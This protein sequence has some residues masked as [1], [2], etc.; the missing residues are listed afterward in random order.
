M[1]GIACPMPGSLEPLVEHA[2]KM[3]IPNPVFETTRV[4]LAY[5]DS[6]SKLGLEPEIPSIDYADEILRTWFKLDTVKEVIKPA[7]TETEQIVQDF[8]SSGVFPEYDI[9]KNPITLS[10][11]SQASLKVSAR[12]ATLLDHLSS[13]IGIPYVFITKET[14]KEI[15]EGLTPWSGEPAFYLGNKIY[16]VS[17]NINEKTAFHEFAH[18]FIRAIKVSNPN[19]YAKLS[20]DLL[21]TV[22][23]RDLLEAAKAKY[24]TSEDDPIL[25]EEAMV[26]ALTESAITRPESAFNTF[27][28]DL[29]YAIKQLLRK[30]FGQ[31]QKVSIEKLSPD[32]TFDQLADMLVLDQFD[33]DLDAINQDD[34]VAYMTDRDAVMQELLSLENTRLQDSTD[35]LFNVISNQLKKIERKK[36]YKTLA[37]ILKDAYNRPDL[38]EIR[39]NLA[40]YQTLSPKFISEFNKIKDDIEYAKKHAHA[41]L[42]SMERLKKMSVK[43][44]E[45][46]TKMVKEK[47]N[48]D[49]VATVFYYNN[50][51]TS[52][53]TFTDQFQSVLKEAEKN[54]ELESDSEIAV[55]TAS[56]SAEITKAKGLTNEIYKEGVSQI[57][58][59]TVAPLKQTIDEKFE[60]IIKD[61]KARELGDKVIQI[62]MAD[63]YGL[64]GEDLNA[65][66]AFK[67]RVDAGEKLRGTE[68]QNYETLKLISYKN[69][70][71]INDEKID[72]LMSGALGD[73]HATNSFLEGYIYNQ[74]LIVSNFSLWV[75]N[76]MTDVLT[77]AQMLGNEFIKDVQP[78]LNRAGYNQANPAQFFR[79]ITF[80]D[81]RGNKE[82]NGVKEYMV[83][84]FINPHKDYRKALMDM[85]NN[86]MLADQKALET[87]DKS[88]A[89]LLRVKRDEFMRNF[90]HTPYTDEYYERYKIFR[91]LGENDE[92]GIAA[93]ALRKEKQDQIRLR[94]TMLD[95]GTESENE[96]TH[97]EIK[98]LV[99]EYRYLFSHYDEAGNLKSDKDIQIADRLRE[100]RDASKDIFREELLPN[101]FE[102]TIKAHEEMLIAKGLPRGSRGFNNMRSNFIRENTRVKINK[103][104]YE[105][106]ESLYKEI[107]QI[108]KKIA[109]KDVDAELNRLQKELNDLMSPYKDDDLQVEGTIINR[110]KVA[111]VKKLQQQIDALRNK[112]STPQGLT[113]EE[114]DQYNLLYYK[115]RNREPLTKEEQTSWNNLVFKKYST[116][117]SKDEIKRLAD[118]YAE[119]N[120]LSETAPTVYYLDMM[121][122]YYSNVSDDIREEFYNTYGSQD[123]SQKLVDIYLTEE[124]YNN[125]VSK[126]PAFKEWYDA[127]HIFTKLSK[128]NGE[129]I[130]K[131]KRV[132]VWDTTVPK[133]IA[134]Y[135]T[136]SFINSEGKKEVMRGIPLDTFYRRV[137]KDEYISKTVTM[138][139]ALEK[140]DPTLATHDNKGNALPKLNA[141][142]NRFINEKFFEIKKDKPK[143]D[144]L[145]ALMKWSLK[146]QDGKE[147]SSKLYLDLPRFGLDRYE[148]MRNPDEN[149]ISRWW[150]NVR[151]MFWTQ[152]DEDSFDRGFNYKE[153]IMLLPGELFD[154][155][156]AGV[157][158]SG[159]SK[160]PDNEVSLDG[161]SS[162][163]RY[164]LSS[165]KQKALIEMLPTARALQAV[166]HDPSNY[167]SIQ[168]KLTQF[169]QKNRSLSKMYDQITKWKQPFR[170]K[171]IRQKAIDNFI[172]REFEGKINKG[173]IGSDSES[174]RLQKIAQTIMS[175]SAF[176][177][178]A[179]DIPSA[180]KNDFSLRIQAAIEAAGG[181]YFDH[182]SL[183]KGTFWANNSTWEISL[184][185][186]S[187]KP[188]THNEQLVMLFDAFQGRF[189]DK[190]DEMMSRSLTKD[191]IGNLKWMT[192]F[193]K[194]TELNSTLSIFGAMM[195]H[196]KNVTRVVDGKETKISYMDAWETVDGQIRLKEGV[197][198]EWGQEGAKFKQFKNKVQGVINNLAGSFAKFD[199]AEADRYFAYRFAIAFKR[200]F[201]RMFLHRFQYRGSIKNIQHRYDNAVG[202][203][204]M[205][206]YIEGLRYLWRSIKAGSDYARGAT[207]SEKVAMFRMLADVAY[208]TLF[209]M[210]ISMLFDFD[211]D[212]ED[213]FKKLRAKSGPLPFLGTGEGEDDFKFKGWLSNHALYMLMQLKQEQTQWLPIPGIGA[214]NYIDMLSLDSVAMHNTW[215]NYK[216][217]GT[218]LVDHA[219]HAIF[220]TDDSKAYFDQRE[221]PY[222]WMQ[223]GGS[224]TMTY[225]A[226]SYGLTG[227]SL[228]PAM[229]VTNF[230]KAQNWR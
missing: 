91:K 72:Y 217:I 140:G 171:S 163:L 219:S 18:P 21:N 181:K 113:K 40:S 149:P 148:I 222:D 167:T 226:R 169:Q 35:E 121:N 51:L 99:R 106:R 108:E 144:A 12:V 19:L 197:D 94:K 49:T 82:G 136:H 223:E 153:Q 147:D 103:A 105:K 199:Y 146:F 133:N 195:Y 182:R 118:L 215:D 4:Y 87:G 132:K 17:E 73:A 57:I 206:Y 67:A 25:I 210:A 24:K 66:L 58:R 9:L 116:Q 165:E 61:A 20:G 29:M 78:I 205:G 204:A 128:K 123:D 185:I 166:L 43:M 184:N 104:F 46:I 127:N 191:A 214:E 47:P 192:S 176:G 36:E 111:E 213:K 60:A 33:L 84:T 79:Q 52:W 114:K 65:F 188:K 48:K 220:G 228:D 209:M 168:K 170:E 125:V 30:I 109:N 34:V 86:I 68:A 175:R 151:K 189:E 155:S 115:Q 6:R 180:L 198:P 143:Y 39:A 42:Q 150:K 23:G 225:L 81:R 69:G 7:E 117:L 172:E 193:R 138:V 122:N 89:L 1:K 10:A 229:A 186:Y 5:N 56:I 80:L 37:D 38:E 93:E 75:K 14:A 8:M 139:E 15:T 224:K 74:D 3:G 101:I 131:I 162:L 76:K 202:D 178:F 100:Y 11:P 230:I 16:I 85:D 161:I 126:S 119:V 53:E 71:Y 2:T 183:S 201:T 27:I 221:G 218:G 107:E 31:T 22:A 32:T 190:F 196:E 203:Q 212:D 124:F 152:N 98:Q 174:V 187:D 216:K 129:I 120:S 62:R 207:D 88:E 227:K 63:Y 173:A 96:E 141:P 59:E 45:A 112:K 135:E 177:Y 142:D 110:D 208:T 77:R 95:K 92:I 64:S 194:W 13:N 134:Y 158:I 55:L 164:A 211:P 50:I 97:K 145:L 156:S 28:K 44:T 102:D 54:N 159:L 154:D 70:A 157:P 137:V 83:H 41:F 179:L 200:W 90:F 130:T 160:L 26:M